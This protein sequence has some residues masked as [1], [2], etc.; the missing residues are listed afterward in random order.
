MLTKQLPWGTHHQVRIHGFQS[1][2][3]GI[4]VFEIH[5]PLKLSHLD[6]LDGLEHLRGLDQAVQVSLVQQDDDATVRHSGS[7]ELYH[8]ILLFI[9]FET[10]SAHLFSGCER[11]GRILR[12]VLH[13]LLRLCATGIPAI[14]NTG[15]QKKRHFFTPWCQFCRH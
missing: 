4:K 1:N 12:D 8:V 7:G 5:S 15:M 10:Y 6:H 11:L 3:T 9:L 13:H 2:V 14:R